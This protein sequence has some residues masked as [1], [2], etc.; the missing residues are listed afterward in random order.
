MSCGV[1]PPRKKRTRGEVQAEKAA[2]AV[3]KAEKKAVKAGPPTKK[4]LSRLSSVGALERYEQEC[5]PL[6]ASGTSAFDTC[7]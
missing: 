5:A 2:K 1:A 4:K 7:I 3:E 6:S